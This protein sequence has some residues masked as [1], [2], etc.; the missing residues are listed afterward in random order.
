MK[1]LKIILKTIFGETEVEEYK[2][3]DEDWENIEKLSND[4]YRTWEWN[5]GRNPKYNFEREEKFEKD[6]YK[7]S[8][9]LNEVKSNMQK[10]SVISLVSEMS[11]ILKMH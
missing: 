6:L 9:M 11:L 7:L 1:N 5:Y 3:T 10:F 2:L 4:K 8:L